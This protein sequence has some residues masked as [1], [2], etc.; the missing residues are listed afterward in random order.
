M[1]IAEADVLLLTTLAG[2]LHEDIDRL[3]ARVIRA[4]VSR[5]RATRKYGRKSVRTWVPRT[6][7]PQPVPDEPVMP[8]PPTHDDGMTE[9]IK[10]DISVLREDGVSWL[11]IEKMY[12]A[13]ITKAAQAHEEEEET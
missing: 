1:N 13:E 2:E 4:G 9:E 11:S 7:Q 3:V 12:G 8:A 6:T 5:I 10:H